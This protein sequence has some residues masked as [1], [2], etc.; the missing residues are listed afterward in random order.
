MVSL[1]RLPQR[2]TPVPT[3]WVDAPF[4]GPEQ[5]VWA[6]AGLPVPRVDGAY[7]WGGN[8]DTPHDPLSGLAHC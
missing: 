1:P 8:V 3:R 4:A 2:F 7:V 6:G 5:P